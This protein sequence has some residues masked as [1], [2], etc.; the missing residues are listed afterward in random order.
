MGGAE[1]GACEKRK[2]A[3]IAANLLRLAKHAIGRILCEQFQTVIGLA[4]LFLQAQLVPLES[5]LAVA[6]AFVENFI[7]FPLDVAT[8]T[9]GAV[10]NLSKPLYQVG[11]DKECPRHARMLNSIESSASRVNSTRLRLETMSNNATAFV[12][13]LESLVEKYR[14]GVSSLEFLEAIECQ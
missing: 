6:P 12:G 9:L 3:N 4:K 2:A 10:Q 11:I 14:D 8:Q 1:A 5:A 13:D 7:V